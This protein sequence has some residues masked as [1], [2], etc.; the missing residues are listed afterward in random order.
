MPCLPID[1]GDGFFSSAHSGFWMCARRTALVS[2][3]VFAPLSVS[4][5][6][7]SCSF[8]CGCKRGSPAYF[9]YSYLPLCVGQFIAITNL[10]LKPISDLYWQHGKKLFGQRRN[11]NKSKTNEN[12]TTTTTTT[13]SVY[14]YRNYDRKWIK[15]NGSAECEQA[16]KAAKNHNLHFWREWNRQMCKRPG[17]DHILTAFTGQRAVWNAWNDRDGLWPDGQCGNWMCASETHAYREIYGKSTTH[18]K[19]HRNMKTANDHNGLNIPIMIILKSM[20]ASSIPSV[21]VRGYRHM[22]QNE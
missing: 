14:V 15:W 12:D 10:R 3:I 1:T 22:D 8:N 20:R 16:L 17:M 4:L 5:A 9:A 13:T 18:R 2:P 6:A 11:G 19:I 7:R 21:N